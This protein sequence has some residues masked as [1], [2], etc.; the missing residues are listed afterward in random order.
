LF[1]ANGH[2]DDMIENY[3]LQ[4]K[5]QGAACSLSYEGGKL[6]NVTAS[7]ALLS[8]Q[9]SGAWIGGGRLRQ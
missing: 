6:T 9:L 8:S 1:L 3:S 7:G 5:I 2:P 4:V